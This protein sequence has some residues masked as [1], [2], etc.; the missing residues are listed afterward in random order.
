[1]WTTPQL[2]PWR[3]EYWAAMPIIVNIYNRLNER[4][5]YDFGCASDSCKVVPNFKK[6]I[7]QHFVQDFFLKLVHNLLD[8]DREFNL[9]VGNE[10]KLIENEYS[11]E[12]I[13]SKKYT[14]KLI[15]EC[16]EW[17]NQI[18]FVDSFYPKNIDEFDDKLKLAIDF[19]IKLSFPNKKILFEY[20]FT[21]GFKRDIIRAINHRDKILLSI[22]KKLIFTSSE[23][24]KELN[25]EYISKRKE[26]RFRVTQRPSSTRIHY[27]LHNSSIKFLKYY[28]EGEHDDGL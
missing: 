2:H 15:N 4:T 6:E 21:N 27:I 16:K 23:A 7:S 12:N 1:M 20:E 14:P 28:D 8:K 3:Q 5:N 10:N 19:L 17:L 26:Y 22:T 13:H 11:F 25:D 18:D 24:L 9:C